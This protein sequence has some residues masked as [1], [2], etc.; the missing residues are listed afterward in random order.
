MGKQDNVFTRYIAKFGPDVKAVVFVG[1][2]TA[3]VCN[4]GNV[5][6]WLQPPRAVPLHDER[7]PADVANS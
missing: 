2:I 7:I 1:K 4:I 5:V 3:I 6:V